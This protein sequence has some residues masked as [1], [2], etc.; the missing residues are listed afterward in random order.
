[1]TIVAGCIG[2]EGREMVA[3]FEARG[4]VDH[5]EILHTSR[6][7]A[8]AVASSSLLRCVLSVKGDDQ[9]CFSIAHVGFFPR[10]SRSLPVEACGTPYCPVDKLSRDALGVA[11]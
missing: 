4:F 11:F 10:R 1:M 9:A 2:G 7:H 6:D 3:M 5:Q 8:I